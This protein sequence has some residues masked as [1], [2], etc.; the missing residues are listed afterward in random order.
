MLEDHLAG[1]RRWPW[2]CSCLLFWASPG[3]VHLEDNQQLLVAPPPVRLG[4]SLFQV[5]QHCRGGRTLVHATPGSGEW[6]L[7][8]AAFVRYDPGLLWI[9]LVAVFLQ[10]VFGYIWNC[11]CRRL[12]FDRGLACKYQY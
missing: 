4:Q 12:R 1:G 10:T 5:G 3:Y 7:G 6:L 9:T 8:L 11:C 2:A